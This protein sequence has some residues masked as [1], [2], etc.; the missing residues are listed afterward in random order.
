[1]Y[2]QNPGHILNAYI[3]RNWNFIYITR[4]FLNDIMLSLFKD[5]IFA[6][7]VANASSELIENAFKNS[8]DDSDFNIIIDD[9]KNE[10]LLEIRNYSKRDSKQSYKIIQDELNKVYAESD[11][12]ESFKK[13][14]LEFVNSPDENLMLGFA[15][16]RLETDARI[17]ADLEEGGVISVKAHF[18]K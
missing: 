3:Y 5:K 15:K 12:K 13:K 14:I 2:R 6:E 17:S 10:V 4:R 1:M 11:P 8:P 9:K 7:K 16:I 18:P